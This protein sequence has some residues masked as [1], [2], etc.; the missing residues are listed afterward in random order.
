M[1]KS[2]YI[3]K[4]NVHNLDSPKEIVPELIKLLNPKSVVDFGCGLGT[5]LY[6]FKQEGVKDVLGLDGLWAN[7]DMLFKYLSPNEFKECNLEDSIKLEKKF[8]LVISLEV[9]EHLS[10]KSADTFVQNLI[11]AGDLIVFGASIPYQEG[12]NHINE[13]WLDYWEQKFLDQ[14]YKMIDVLRPIF[15]DNPNVFWWYK[16]NMVLFIPKEND[17]KSNYII[18]NVLKKLVHYEW[19]LDKSERLDLLTNSNAETKLYFKYLI[20]SI[21]KKIHRIKK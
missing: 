2:K 19:Y 3:H 4:T 8:D 14:G 21:L 9:A 17:F 7:K 11:G 1:K 12:Q 15:W 18:N 13:Q 10:E 20:K 6:C 5:F 16:Q